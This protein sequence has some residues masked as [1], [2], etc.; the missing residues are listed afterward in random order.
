M[1]GGIGIAALAMGHNA[2]GAALVFAGVG[3]MVAVVLLLSSPRK[4]RA[5]LTQGPFPLI[6][7]VL[8]V[9]GLTSS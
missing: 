3:S 8:L 9:L 1:L 5:A 7:N 6:A 2:V 4:V